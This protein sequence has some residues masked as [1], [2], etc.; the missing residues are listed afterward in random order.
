M[1]PAPPRPLAACLQL[2]PRYV[3]QLQAVLAMP[4]SVGVVGGRPGSSLYFVGAQGGSVLYL[5]PH[6]VQPAA[7]SE[8]DWGSHHCDVL[9]TMGL[10]AIDPSLA[11]G[12]YAASLGAQPLLG[13]TL[14]PLLL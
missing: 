4:Q 2:N 8:A 14:G 3:P 12:F 10:A 6:Q 1:P 5:D 7:A 13:P 9:R 11:L